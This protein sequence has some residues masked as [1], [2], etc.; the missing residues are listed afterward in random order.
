[1][2]Q[3]GLDKKV[4]EAYQIHYKIAPAIDFIFAEGNPA[5]IKAVFRK[6]GICD[7]TVR[8]PLVRVTDGLRKKIDA[9]VDEF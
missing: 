9:F 6:L 8:L 2:V 5:G 1:M 3:L 7:D 4:D